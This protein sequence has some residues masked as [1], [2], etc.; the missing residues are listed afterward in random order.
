MF[1]NAFFPE[2]SSGGEGGGE[3]IFLMNCYASFR[4]LHKRDIGYISACSW[5][6]NEIIVYFMRLRFLVFMRL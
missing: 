4:V 5:L 3:S 2:R 6:A 1:I